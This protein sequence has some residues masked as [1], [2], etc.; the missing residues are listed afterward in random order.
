[1]SRKPS[2]SPTMLFSIEQVA[3]RLNV[4]V[5]TVRRWIKRGELIAHKLGHLWRIS[6]ADF[7][8]FLRERREVNLMVSDEH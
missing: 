4:S 3:I 7:E 5:V 2:P 1:M 8:L 6:E